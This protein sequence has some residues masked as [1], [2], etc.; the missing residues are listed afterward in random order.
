MF[1]HIWRKKVHLCHRNWLCYFGK[2]IHD[3][4]VKCFYYKQNELNVEMLSYKM[5]KL[6]LNDIEEHYIHHI[7][8]KVEF[9]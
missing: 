3:A 1:M 9:R 4:F 2:K 7:L 5:R 8:Y 6:Y